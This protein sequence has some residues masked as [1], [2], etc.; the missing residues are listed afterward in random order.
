MLRPTSILLAFLPLILA[1]CSD[2]SSV[3]KKPVV[4]NSLSD[5]DLMMI[6]HC[7]EMKMDQCEKYEGITLN[8]AQI[9]QS[10]NL[11]PEMMMCEEKN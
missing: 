8:E 2:S 1:A 6:M 7:A 3:D 5:E 10:C 4:E 11:M 9:K